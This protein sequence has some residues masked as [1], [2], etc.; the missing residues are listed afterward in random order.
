DLKLAN[1]PIDDSLK[2]RIT[3]FGLSEIRQYAISTIALPNSWLSTGVGT[4]T[5]MSPQALYGIMD[6]I[7]DAYAFAMTVYE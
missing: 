6:K 2:L 5:Y 7:S 4:L 3:G 1:V